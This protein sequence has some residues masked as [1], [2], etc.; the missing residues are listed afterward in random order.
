MAVV[1]DQDDSEIFTVTAQCYGIL[2][3]DFIFSEE[4]QDIIAA[5]RQT[6]WRS[7]PGF[8]GWSAAVDVRKIRLKPGRHLVK[9]L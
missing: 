2:E 1:V 7:R 5:H 8:R 3:I 9:P 6:E 4:Q